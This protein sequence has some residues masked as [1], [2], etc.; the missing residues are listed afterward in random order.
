MQAG[1]PPGTFVSLTWQTEEVLAFQAGSQLGLK[2]LS[3]ES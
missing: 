2:V 1:V 3:F